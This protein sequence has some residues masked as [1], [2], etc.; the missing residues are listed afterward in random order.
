[1][2]NKFARQL[3]RL[4]L[5]AF[6]IGALPAGAAAT[7]LDAEL[8]EVAG[9]GTRLLVKGSV[10]AWVFLEFI[11]APPGVSTDDAPILNRGSLAIGPGRF[12][13]A[14]TPPP[15]S[16]G[17]TWEVS[18]YSAR[19]P[20]EQCPGGGCITCRRDGYHLEGRLLTRRGQI[21]AAKPAP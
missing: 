2:R 10:E 6:L 21:P 8:K 16:R 12:S 15:D 17:G 7:S 4:W 11:F 18:L 3:T 13:F 9:A 19:V 14:W 20:R 5:L 1:M